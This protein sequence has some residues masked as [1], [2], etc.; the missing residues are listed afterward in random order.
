MSAQHVCHIP[1]GTTGDEGWDRFSFSVR[2][3]DYKRKIEERSLHLCVRFSVDGH[4]WWDSN[5]GKNYS[6]SFKRAIVVRPPVAAP[7]PAHGPSLFQSPRCDSPLPEHPHPHLR[8]LPRTSPSH[9]KSPRNWIFPRTAADKVVE[10]SDSPQL[11]P[12]PPVSFKP[13]A[14]PDVHTHLR[15]KKY[16]A[17]SPPQSPPKRMHLPQLP[18]LVLSLAPVRATA[19]PGGSGSGSGSGAVP[20][21]APAMDLIHGHPA[22][23][24]SPHERS[25]SWAGKSGEAWQQQNDKQSASDNDESV[26]G[27]STPRAARARSPET[28]AP[29]KADMASM[30]DSPVSITN[31]SSSSGSEDETD[32][33]VTLNRS[34]GDLRALINQDASNGLMT[35]PSSNLSSPPTPSAVLPGP[36]SPSMSMST[37]DSSPVNTLIS[38]SPA[39]NDSL[40]E[41]RGRT[42]NAATYQ[43]FLDKFCFFKSP[44][45]VTTPLEGVSAY[46]RPNYISNS[47]YSSPYYGYFGAHA[48]ATPTQLAHD[49]ADGGYPL[50]QSASSTGSG[51]TPRA[52]PPTRS[53]ASNAFPLPCDA[54][55]GTSGVPL[56]TA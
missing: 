44:P 26:G 45:S 33:P 2:L 34:T 49:G 51:A 37:G 6:V 3:E 22:T 54:N 31:T 47:G 46:T 1:A 7:V 10:R 18:P 39:E 41:A 28:R 36:M 38:G 17:P 53:P 14:P 27:D 43:E 50:G 48:T 52:S 20:V 32:R 55:T 29:E 16:C 30:V 56:T 19:T 11:S 40:D 15:L 24:W 42:L 23:T 5:E 35:P 12:P 25:H 21:A 13:P 9:A 8:L 4:E